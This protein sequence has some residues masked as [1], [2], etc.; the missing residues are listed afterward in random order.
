MLGTG[1]NAIKGSKSIIKKSVYEDLEE[2]GTFY[3]HS[4]SSENH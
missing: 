3:H 4:R 2:K 1:I